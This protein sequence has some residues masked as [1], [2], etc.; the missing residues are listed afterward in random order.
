MG[1]RDRPQRDTGARWSVEISLYLGWGS[2]YKTVYYVFQDSQNCT[3]TRVNFTVYELI[4]KKQNQNKCSR[5][6]CWELD[7]PAYVHTSVK[8]A[9]HSMLLLITP[10]FRGVKIRWLCCFGRESHFHGKGREGTWLENS[11]T[12]LLFVGLVQ[13]ST[14]CAPRARCSPPPVFVNKV[15]LEHGHAG[16]FTWAMAALTL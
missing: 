1:R 10:I 15:S 4:L 6:L 3:L 16:L 14:N 8:K 5:F 9:L 11:N 13:G 7:V 2:V 12:S